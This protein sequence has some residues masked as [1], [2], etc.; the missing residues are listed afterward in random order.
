MNNNR[1][2]NSGA[3]PIWTILTIA[4]KYQR[5]VEHTAS[6]IRAEVKQ[7]GKVAHCTEKTGHGR[8]ELSIGTINGEG[9]RIETTTLLSSLALLLRHKEGGQFPGSYNFSI[10]SNLRPLGGSIDGSFLPALCVCP[11]SIHPWPTVLR[12]R[13]LMYLQTTESGSAAKSS[14]C[15]QE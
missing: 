13:E 5:S 9:L 6:I 3:C 4:W 1:I 2:L 11:M 15:Q 12:L 14:V 10:A 8:Q 7:R